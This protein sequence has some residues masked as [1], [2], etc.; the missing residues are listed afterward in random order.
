MPTESQEASLASILVARFLRTHNYTQTLDAFLRE[1][2]LP[3]NAGQLRDK[4]EGN[5]WTIEG[6]LEEK[7]AFDQSVNFERYGEDEKEKGIWSVP[8]PTKPNIVATPTA[9]N[10]LACSVEQ[11]QLPSDN[12]NN[13]NEHLNAPSAYLVATGADKHLNLFQTSAGYD[14]AQSFSGTSEAPILSYAPI[15]GGKCALLTNMSGQLLLQR[16]AEILDRRKDHAK[17]AVK[18]VTHEDSNT[19]GSGTVW[20][21]TAGWDSKIFLYRTSLTNDEAAP[22]TIGEPVASIPLP[23]NPESILFV[24]HIDTN[25]LI[26]LVSRRDSTYLYYYR[27]VAPAQLRDSPYECVCL[28]KQNLAPHSNAWVAFSPSCLALSPLDPGLLAIAT[29][30]LPHMKVMIVRLL[31]PAALAESRDAGADA[32]ANEDAE[33]Q[34]QAA[35]AFAALSLQNREDAAILIQA[36]TFAPQTA[37]STPQVVWRPDGSGVW[38]NGDDGVIRGVETKTGKVVTLLK[39][40]HQV[41]CKIRAIWA[42][43]VETTAKGGEV[44]REEW[45][46]SG[47]FDKRLVVWKVE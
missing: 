41:G 13:N 47:G 11:W 29:S 31:F 24:R 40:G 20:I 44:E 25:E 14:P 28:G 17:Y 42:G 15:Q 12:N 10:I 39:D 46:V 37:Y 30:T 5:V 35:Q 33:P 38:V 34:T 9:S 45:L 18:V 4:D 3:A 6:V 32:N 26:L 16:G 8:A 22:M 21:A 43:W 27:V 1:A 23:S 2:G 7:K 36:N 19:D